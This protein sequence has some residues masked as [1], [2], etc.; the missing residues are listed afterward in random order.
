MVVGVGM[1]MRMGSIWVG[2]A[3]RKEDWLIDRIE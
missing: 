1:G 2:G 3:G